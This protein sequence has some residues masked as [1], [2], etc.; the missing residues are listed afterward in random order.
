MDCKTFKHLEL[1]HYN[2]DDNPKKDKQFS[3][4][5]KVIDDGVYFQKITRDGDIEEHWLCSPLEMT[6]VTCDE[7]SLTGVVCRRSLIPTAVST[8][9]AMSIKLTAGSS[10]SIGFLKPIAMRIYDE[11][12]TPGHENAEPEKGICHQQQNL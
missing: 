6:T 11:Q 1:D 8:I 4:S 3:F 2:I 12:A 9:G 7:D 5:F 10:K